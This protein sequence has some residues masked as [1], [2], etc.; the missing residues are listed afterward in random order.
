MKDI[1][2]IW[3]NNGHFKNHDNA[4]KLMERSSNTPILNHLAIKVHFSSHDATW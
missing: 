4:P 3:D 2:Q 1:R